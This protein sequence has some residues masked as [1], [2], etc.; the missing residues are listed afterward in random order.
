MGYETILYDK[1]G[2]VAYITLNRPNK[3]NSV[4]PD[5]VI[6]WTKA[7]TEAEEDDD[8]KVIVFRGAG[9][10][11]SAGAPLDKVGF[12]YGMQEPKP[13]EKPPKVPQRVK[14]KFD[15]NLFYDFH[16]R[17]L[18]CKKLTIAQLHEYCL[19]VAFTLVMHCDL[20]I[21]SEDCK[22][23]HVE[24]RLGLGGMTISPI[25]VLR[26]GLTRAMDLCLTGK[27]I[28]GKQAA[29]YNLINRAVP[30]E[31]LEQEV[32]DLANGLALYPKDGIAFGKVTRE[33]MYTTMGVDRGLM[34]HYVMHSFQT[35]R[36]YDPGEFNFF[37]QRKDKGVRDAAHDKHDY[38]KAL[39]K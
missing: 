10:C 17:I 35:N 6:D 36:V 22:M 9:R 31:T 13:G 28:T 29:E 12:V 32:R 25:M 4:S 34:D 21:A 27:M 18:Y 30:K 15:R 20:L 33:M 11:F 2:Q 39:D 16:R 26:C 24:E 3:L 14:L 37:K 1:E 5:L 7:I 19:G 8:V 23:G 38:F